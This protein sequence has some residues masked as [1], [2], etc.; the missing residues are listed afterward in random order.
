VI[1]AEQWAENRRMVLGERCSQRDVARRLGLA[2]VCPR[3]GGVEAGSVQAVDR[4]AAPG[5]CADTAAAGFAANLSRS[6]FS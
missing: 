4:R 3:S 1:G 2:R 6:R 5:G